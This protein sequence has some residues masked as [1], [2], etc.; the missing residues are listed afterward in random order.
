MTANADQITYWNDVA[1]AKWVDG[2][3][4]LDQLMAPLTEA[5]LEHAAPRPGEHVMDV[6]C[7]CGDLTFRLA[8]ALGDEGHVTAVDVSKPMLKHAAARLARLPAAP[9][10]EIEWLGADAM[11]HAF[12][13]EQDLV[14]SRFGVMFFDDRPRA[15]ANLRA[16]IKPGGRFAFLAWQGRRKVEWM[17]E[18]L[19]WV[20][21][22]F[23]TTPASD[24][25]IGPFGLANA[26]ETRDTLSRAGLRD[27]TAEPIERTLPIGRNADEATAMLL[28]AG[29]ASR[30]FRDATSDQHEQA[31]ALLRAAV[32]RRAAA[33]AVEMKGACWLYQGRA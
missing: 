3:E 7:G 16:A 5:L 24:G 31:T 18:P 11:T 6:G 27:V 14:A 8:H 13:P 30:L 2:Q 26:D 28:R 29:P 20:A 33:G 21:P 12:A 23:G 10:A 1:G 15:F 4:E 17:H 9:R 25:E 22:V 32:E 19:E